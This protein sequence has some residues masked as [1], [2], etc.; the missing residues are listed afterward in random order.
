MHWPTPH[1]P[2]APQN[3]PIAYL[4]GSQARHTC[5]RPRHPEQD[6]GEDEGED[7]D[8]L[9][10]S[11]LCTGMPPST[12]LEEIGIYFA[13]YGEGDPPE[14]KATSGGVVVTFAR[15][16]VAQAMMTDSPHSMDGVTKLGMK[17]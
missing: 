15:E 17:R 10:L 1:P 16:E 12:G 2:S 14:C 7:T 6:K 13:Q 8:D 9:S 5:S 3:S 11:F 4:P